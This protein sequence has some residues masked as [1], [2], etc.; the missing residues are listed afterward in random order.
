MNTKCSICN[1]PVW[2]NVP[3][4]CRR[5]EVRFKEGKNVVLITNWDLKGRSQVNPPSQDNNSSSFPSEDG[6]GRS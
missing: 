4:I 6:D 2:H 1:K 5:Q 3:H